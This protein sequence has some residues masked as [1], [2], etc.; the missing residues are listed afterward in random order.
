[1]AETRRGPG[2]VGIFGI[3]L[4]LGSIAF[5]AWWFYKPRATA[6]VIVDPDAV[7]VYCSGRVDA[8]GQVIPLEPTQGGRVVRIYPGVVEGATVVK[9]Q[10]LIAFDDAYA[11]ARCN[12]AAASRD[13][14]RIEV[15]FA[16][17]AKD[18]FPLM[19][20]ARQSLL[21]ASAARVEAAEKLLLQRREQ[22][23]ITPIGRYELEAMDAQ[24]KELKAMKD[25]ESAQVEDLKKNEGDLV[26]RHEAALVRLRAAASELELAEKLKADCVLLAPGP[27]TILR[28]QAT[29][30]GIVAPGTP[31]P[32][33][34][35]A[36]AGPYVI[37]AE[38]DQEA[39]GRVSEGMAA[40]AT[41]ENRPEGP[42]WKGKLKHLGGWVALRRTM[43]LEPGEISDLRTIECLIELDSGGERLWI[44]QRMR[45]RIVRNA[46]AK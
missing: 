21:S 42:Q 39:L 32:P 19:M 24:I 40:I 12:Q 7:D 5:G 18:R 44:G 16:A 31:I 13:G 25:A 36:P 46:Q 8:A 28:F 15:E 17:K 43:I 26:L 9:D 35:F 2:L 1:M 14:A 27:G 20:V 37:R 45:V 22:Q 29:L 33:I 38:V 11:A 10:P 34:V 4:L 3:L 41:D 23:S 6:E 30:G